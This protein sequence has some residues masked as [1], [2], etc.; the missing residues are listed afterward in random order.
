[1]WWREGDCECNGCRNRNYAFSTFCNRC[2]RLRLLVNYKT[3]ADSKWLP[4]IGD[5]ICTANEFKNKEKEEEEMED[6]EEEACVLECEEGQTSKGA[7]DDEGDDGM[8]DI[9]EE[10]D[11]K[12]ERRKRGVSHN[13]LLKQLHRE[14]VREADLLGEPSGHF[15]DYYVLYG[16]PKR[17]KRV[18][19]SEKYGSPPR[20]MS[21]PTGWIT[22]EEALENSKKEI[23]ETEA[24]CDILHVDLSQKDNSTED[25]QEVE[26]DAAE[27]QSVSG[28]DLM[29]GCNTNKPNII[30][31]T[32][33]SE[34]SAIPT[35]LQVSLQ[36]PRVPA[37]PTLLGK[38]AKQWRDI[39]IIT[40][41]HLEHNVIGAKLREVVSVA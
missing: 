30:Y 20:I 6:N 4:R 8:T 25:K 40:I 35:T 21:P 2:K 37:A 14:G 31:P 39:A 13:T 7:Y 12:A 33:P 23:Q 27:K 19:R 1:P 36:V 28:F 10:I 9:E 22:E 29:L 32:I 16:T 15:F 17:K 41:M 11:L 18:P 5:W 3:P 34:N 24:Q 38:G 26:I